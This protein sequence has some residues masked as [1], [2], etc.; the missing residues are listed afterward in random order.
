VPGL[1][2][3]YALGAAMIPSLSA[4]LARTRE[5]LAQ[6][7]PTS[8][9]IEDPEDPLQSYPVCFDL[10]KTRRREFSAKGQPETSRSE[11]ATAADSRR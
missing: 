4:R 11:R 6:L 10:R 7:D 5:L 1:P 2:L 3:P 9:L 8:R